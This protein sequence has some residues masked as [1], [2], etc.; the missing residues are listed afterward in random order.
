MLHRYGY[1][2][3]CKGRHFLKKAEKIYEK[4]LFKSGQDGEFR[5][6]AQLMSVRNVLGKN[7]AS[8]EL[9]KERVLEHPDDPTEYFYLARAY[10]NADQIEEACKVVDA[11]ENICDAETTIAGHM[12]ISG[13]IYARLG[14][15]EKALECWEKSVVDQFGVGGLYSRAFMFKELGRLEEAIAEWKRIIDML[16]GP[17]DPAYTLW[18]RE[19]IAK[20]EA[21]LD[22]PAR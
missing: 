2:F 5:I 22:K 6:D 12:Y 8:I 10:M 18:P 1:L 7:K 19:E 13:D 17:H 21:Q 11:V 15:T 20:L 9:Y 16:E 3:E 4:G 14:E